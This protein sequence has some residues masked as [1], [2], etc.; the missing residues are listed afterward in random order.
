ME[1]IIIHNIIVATSE[2]VSDDINKVKFSLIVTKIQRDFYILQP[3]F[4]K[5]PTL[6]QLKKYLNEFTPLL[7]SNLHSWKFFSIFFSF[8]HSVYNFFMWI[9]K[10]IILQSHYS[11]HL[12]MF[13]ITPENWSDCLRYHRSQAPTDSAS[14]SDGIIHAR[15]TEPEPT[16]GLLFTR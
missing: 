15:I 13:L 9:F 14:S 5:M 7:H 6:K 3:I 4:H 2:F 11:D 16:I 1:F 12:I 10:N 8:Y